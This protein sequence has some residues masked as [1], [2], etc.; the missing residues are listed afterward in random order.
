MTALHPGED[1]GEGSGNGGGVAVVFGIYGFICLNSGVF[2][3]FLAGHYL[4][5][6]KSKT[7]LLFRT[8]SMNMKDFGSA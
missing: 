3:V 4:I 5:R 1:T 7:E 6:V 2:F 8:V